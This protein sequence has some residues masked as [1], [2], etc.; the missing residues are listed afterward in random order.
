MNNIKELRFDARLTLQAL[1]D[2]SCISKTQVHGLEQGRHTPTL[3]TAYKIARVL[4]VSVYKVW[5][6]TT[7]IVIETISVRR[8]VEKKNE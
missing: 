6:D 3:T 5:P 7:E 1:G 8:C 4:G 2:L